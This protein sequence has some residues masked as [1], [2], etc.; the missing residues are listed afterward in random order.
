MRYQRLKDSLVPQLRALWSAGFGDSA[1][2][3]DDFFRTAA[4][5]C[6]IYAATE[7]ETLAAAAC[8]MPHTVCCDGAEKQAAYL[9][10]VATDPRFRKQGVCRALLGHIEKELKK[11]YVSCV[12]LVPADA[13]LCAMYQRLGYRGAPRG[14]QT[15]N[16]PAACGQAEKTDLISY[17]GL[18]ETLLWDTVHVRYAK[19]L[20]ELAGCSIDFYALRLG[21]GAG[22]AAVERRE[23]GTVLVHELLPDSRFLPALAAAVDAQQVT[24][25]QS[26]TAMVKWLD[27]TQPTWGEIEIGFDFG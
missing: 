15:E 6:T 20:L 14:W 13:A 2:E 22:C 3:L 18:R 11:K 26:N 23:D 17:A 10:A 19:P 12:L 16:L 4:P 25:A 21:S 8:V 5:V 1:Q 24:L 27:E 7:G 9:Y